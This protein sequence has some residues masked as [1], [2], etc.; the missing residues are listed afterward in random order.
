MKALS[1]YGLLLLVAGLLAMPGTITAAEEL[2]T[3]FPTETDPAAAVRDDCR[4]VLARFPANPKKGQEGELQVTVRNTGTTTWVWTD[5]DHFYALGFGPASNYK[6]EVRGIRVSHP[7]GS[8]PRDFRGN[9]I[10]LRAAENGKEAEQIKPGQVKTFGCRIE[11]KEAG[12][13]TIVLRM[14]KENGIAA[15]QKKAR[16]DGWYGQRLETVVVVTD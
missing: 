14:L 10:T 11:C 6:G 5:P 15:G 4:I 13:Q 7:G 16:P 9:R 8:M 1:K 2:Q 3:L 12:P